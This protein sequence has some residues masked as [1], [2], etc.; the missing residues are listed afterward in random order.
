V[1]R[2]GVRFVLADLPAEQLIRLADAVAGVPVL[3]LNV[4]APEDRLRGED[5]RANVAHVYP[6]RQMLTDALAQYLADMGWTD[7]L[8]LVGET[9]A[10]AET[11]AAMRRSAAR[12]GA[13]IV[14]ERPFVLGN[15]PRR[16][17][18]T[19]VAL[20]TAGTDPDVVFVADARG[21]FA[22]NVPYRTYQPRPVVGAAGLMPEAW[23]WTWD[24]YGAPQ[25]QHRFEALAAPRRMN[26]PAW[27]AWVAVKAVM[28]AAM[29]S[30]GGDFATMRAYLLGALRLDGSKGRQMSFRPWD[31]QL[32]QPI[33]LATADAV[34][35]DAPLAAFQHQTNDLDT[36]GVD[37]PE[38]ECR[39]GGTAR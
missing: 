31:Q 19:N 17:D 25:V 33:L 1:Q 32:R 27:A 37:R 11:A 13:E 23:H 36:L 15:D 24:R 3:L 9:G 16:R 20:M 6:S 34:V 18:R 28:Q 39:I 38:T 14:G 22:R 5:C 2:R 30:G 21:E 29:R 35:A 8:M 26:G 10:D 4:S 12:F 7:I